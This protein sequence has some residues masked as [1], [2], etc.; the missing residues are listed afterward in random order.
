[1]VLNPPDSTPR[2]AC[3][4]TSRTRRAPVAPDPRARVPPN[5]HCHRGSGGAAH[6]R[7][8]RHCPL[9]HRDLA[10]GDVDESAHGRRHGPPLRS[11]SSGASSSGTSSD[12]PPPQPRLT[13]STRLP[14]S[15]GGTAFG[16]SGAITG[17]DQPTWLQDE[18]FIRKTASTENPKARP[19]CTWY[20]ERCGTGLRHRAA[21]SEARTVNPAEQQVQQ[22]DPGIPRRCTRSG[23]GLGV[24]LACGGTLAMPHI[25]G[26][27]R[28]TARAWSTR[29]ESRD[30]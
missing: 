16:A 15:H 26:P 11:A 29:G 23:P 25:N 5:P 20:V 30:H 3:G 9:P 8:S 12:A 19:A 18:L 28:V 1:M 22:P 27:A 7:R 2:G 6:A 17:R 24:C 13:N 14:S 21:G 10:Y 4:P